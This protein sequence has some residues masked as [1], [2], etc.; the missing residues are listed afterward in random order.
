MVIYGVR[1]SVMRW[2]PW[3]AFVPSEGRNGPAKRRRA[4]Q[5]LCLLQIACEWNDA[6]LAVF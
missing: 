4:V 6:I 1:F 3:V 5:V 2:D